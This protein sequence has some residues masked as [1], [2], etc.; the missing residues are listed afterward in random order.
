MVSN[1]PP[2]SSGSHSAYLMH[3]SSNDPVERRVDLTETSV[4]IRHPAPS[5]VHNLRLVFIDSDTVQTFP[6]VSV[7]VS[8]PPDPPQLHVLSMKTDSVILGWSHV[9]S[10]PSYRLVGYQLYVDGQR[11]E[12][13][14]IGL[15]PCSVS[16]LTCR[17]AEKYRGGTPLR[18]CLA[19]LVVRTTF[20][21][22]LS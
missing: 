11:C 3:S 7:L 20:L 1:L 6:G 8:G 22:K 4:A 13:R 9:Q 19:R 5:S 17:L 14:C 21:S 18:P 2:S 12:T 16:F 15:F 10:Y